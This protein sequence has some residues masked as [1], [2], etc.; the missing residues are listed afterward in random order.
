MLFREGENWKERVERTE[1]PP[2]RQRAI[3]S[4]CLPFFVF[5]TAF[6]VTAGV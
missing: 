4:S 3:R 2:Q 6:F 1:T 5:L